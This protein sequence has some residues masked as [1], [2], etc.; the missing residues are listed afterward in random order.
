MWIY[1]YIFLYIRIQEQT[2]LRQGQLPWERWS[3]S[4]SL[5]EDVNEN[6][7]YV[8]RWTYIEEMDKK[9]PHSAWRVHPKSI[10]YTPKI[11]EYIRKMA[12]SDDLLSE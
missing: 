10:H 8:P 7:A 6:M 5:L 2:G 3:P 9:A 1:I 12:P 4:E 11:Q